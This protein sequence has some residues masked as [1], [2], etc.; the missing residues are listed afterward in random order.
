MTSANSRSDRFAILLAPV[1][2]EVRQA[3]EMLAAEFYRPAGP[4]GSKDKAPIDVEIE[5]FLRA[6]LTA[7][8][9][10]RFV[11]EE[12][13]AH[14]E[15]TDG[16]CWVVDPN[17]G[18]RDFLRG[19]RGSAV[20]VA[21]LAH[22]RPVLGVVYAPV[23]PDRG[24]DLIAWAEGTGHL[25]RNGAPVRAHLATPALAPGSF[26]FLSAGSHLRPEDYGRLVA[27]ARFIALPSIAY[28]L[29][30]VAAGDGVATA[31]WNTLSPYDIAGGHALIVAAGGVMR[32]RHGIDVRYAANG[33][34]RIDRLF[35][36][37]PAAAIALAGRERVLTERHHPRI[38]PH[39]PHDLTRSDRAIGCLLGQVIGDSLGGLVE[40]KTKSQI[41]TLYPD[42]V[43]NLADGGHWDTLAGQPTDDSELALALARAIVAAGSFDDELVAAS[44]ARW[45]RSEPFDCGQ[46][47]AQALAAAAA[48]G[49]GRRAEA[50]R[51]AADRESQSNGAL[52]RAAPIGIAART[53]SE[54]SAWA[55]RDARLTHPHPVCIAASAALTTAISAGISGATPHEMGEAARA[56][57]SSSPGGQP[58]SERL[59][60]AASGR[61]PADFVTNQGW[62]LT[63]LQNA[64]FHLMHADRAEHALIETAGEGG[65]ADTNGAIAGALLG[66]AY[67]RDAWPARWVLPV[68]AC[69]PL[70]EFGA[71]RPRP[72]EY[73]PD[74]L[75]M[76]AEALLRSG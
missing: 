17:D 52:M 36:G 65:D 9:P 33:E 25:T 61:R 73:W 26:V 53:T 37:A 14:G 55:A 24:P 62:V 50:A 4:R 69:R 71:K 72:E 49:D 47:I 42:G 3:G 54:A 5:Q 67:G 7:L 58:V 22:G 76:L 74:D 2:E 68:L 43:Q 70:A 16:L 29:A 11:G 59:A 66:A 45:Y 32:D 20:S 28:R 57:V 10:A 18:T 1:S 6:R 21:L 15:P 56:A 19:H 35:A 63:A 75:P 39:F 23:P 30:R 64:F 8:L 27:P 46:T 40:F 31:T 13:G 48:A 34:G 12:Q 51:A 60:E 38:E 44:Y 41:G